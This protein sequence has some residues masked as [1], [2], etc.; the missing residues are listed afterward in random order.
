MGLRFGTGQDGDVIIATD[1]TIGAESN[2]KQ[3]EN[4]TV[5]NGVRLKINADTSPAR[6]LCGQKLNLPGSASEIEILGR[7]DTG[8]GPNTTILER[9]GGNG[10]NTLLVQSKHITGTGKIFGQ[11]NPGSD[12]IS[13][14][15]AG[16]GG[17]GAILLI[18]AYTLDNVTFEAQ[19]GDGGDLV[20]G[21]PYQTVSENIS[22]HGVA[23]HFI[24]ITDPIGA[25]Q[26]MRDGAAAGGVLDINEIITKLRVLINIGNAQ[27][28]ET[29]SGGGGA[30]GG[31]GSSTRYSGGGGG[32]YITSGGRGSQLSIFN[33][34]GGAGSGGLI[35]IISKF[36]PVSINVDGGTGGIREST[37]VKGGGDGNQ[38]SYFFMDIGNA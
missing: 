2:F 9:R 27:P 33:G 30:G 22:V 37:G 18:V 7:P 3:Y 15:G 19:G 36:D 8:G 28:P 1:M 17:A 11:L 20:T 29:W 10:G 35:V 31:G 34:G 23:A 16:G 26:G 14:Q 38:G 4:L 25:R 5:N 6:I 24:G 21:T 12:S 13:N 32:S